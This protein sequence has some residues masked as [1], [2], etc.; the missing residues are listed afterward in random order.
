M[1]NKL[2][3]SIRK[4][5]T[6]AEWLERLKRFNYSLIKENGLQAWTVADYKTYWQNMGR[7]I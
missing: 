5:Q 7:T 6:F 2:L 3:R 1:S 4:A